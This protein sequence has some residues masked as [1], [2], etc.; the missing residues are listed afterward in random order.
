MTLKNN[1]KREAVFLLPKEILVVRKFVD[2]KPIDIHVVADVHFGSKE[3]REK[4]FM[5]FIKMIENTPNAYLILAGDLINNATK[6]SVSN[7]F[8]DIY[9]PSEQKK[10]MTKIL[11][12]VKDRILVGTD[13]NH[14][15]RSCKDV[16]DDPMYDI[17]AKLDI[18]DRYR[19]NMAVL[20]INFGD[21]H[22]GAGGAV[23]NPTYVFAVTHGSGGGV[24]TGG[25]VNKAERYI[26]TLEG[27][28]AL[29]TAHTH[30]PLNTTPSRWVVDSRRNVMKEVPMDVIIATSWTRY[31]D[32]AAR[33]M[34]PP[35]SNVLQRITIQGDKK[36][37]EISN[38]HSY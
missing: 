10:I 19:K 4:L 8:D 28:D 6:S 23:R 18:E 14:E 22:R 35:T 32:Y 36:E 26:Y 1:L 24:L 7:S 31:A 2:H 16:D 5:D 17:F 25:S 37:I 12:P 30:K 33:K 3:C 21:S 15:D 9:R 11:E 20:K 29:I 13:G 34:M 38:K 27:V